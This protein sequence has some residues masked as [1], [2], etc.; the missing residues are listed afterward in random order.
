MCSETNSRTRMTLVTHQAL[1]RR[2]EAAEKEH[3]ALAG[4][5]DVERANLTKRIAEL[6]QVCSAAAQNMLRF[7]HSNVSN[8]LV[9]VKGFAMMFS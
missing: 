2:W 9:L 4:Q 5:L 1:Q 7:S 8:S 6:E 3:Q